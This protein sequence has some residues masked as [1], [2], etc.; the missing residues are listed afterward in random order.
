MY[1]AQSTI[2]FKISIPFFGSVSY[3]CKQVTVVLA[4]LV[5]INCCFAYSAS[6]DSINRYSVY[7][8]VGGINFLTD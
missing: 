8:L 2:T 5:I 1:K 4:A 6:L 7:K 3:K